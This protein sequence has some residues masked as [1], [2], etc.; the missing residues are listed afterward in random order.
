MTPA[1][2]RPDL[3]P[4]WLAGD[5]E[6][7]DAT[8]ADGTPI[9]G[10]VTGRGDALPLVCCDGLGCDGYIW[11]YLVAAFAPTRRIVRFHYRGHGRSGAPAAIDRFS[12]ESLGDDLESVLDTAG[13][14]RAV[15]LGHSVGAQV[16][17]D[18]HRR[19][20][21]RVAGLVPVCGTYGRVVDTF[22][23]NP[24]SRWLFP[25]VRRL[26]G[27]Y[28]EQARA[29]WRRLDS[30]LLY[31]LATVTDVNGRLVHREDFRP[32]FSH[33]A[34][35][36]VRHFFALAEDAARS[37]NLAHLPTIDV[38]TLIITGERDR[39]TPDWLGEVMHRRIPASELLVVPGGSHTAPI[40]MPELI[41]LRIARFLTER[42]AQPTLDG[43]SAQSA[44]A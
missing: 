3:P 1:N 26:V 15:L 35:M 24:V 32:Y 5:V 42:L 10:Y 7:F 29:L 4:D 14:G 8:S 28:P 44:V 37:D 13:L 27:R 6:T 21:R 38:P 36:D 19:Q 41:N 18:F 25:L 39:F 23:D 30:D 2:A 22:H 33:L 20:P 16:I 43:V 11:K 31:D 17:V 9:H 40:E 12:L 34:T